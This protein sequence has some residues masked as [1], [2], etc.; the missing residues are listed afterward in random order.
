MNTKFFYQMLLRV[1]F[2]FFCPAHPTQC[3][4]R[5]NIPEGAAVVCPNHTTLNDPFMVCYAFGLRHQLQPM[6]KAELMRIP[7]IGKI[8]EFAGVI[9]VSRGQADMKAAK[10]ALK[11]LK[12]GNKLLI[13]PEGTRVAEGEEVEAKSGAAFFA[14]RTGAPMLPVYIPAK[15][16]WFRRTKVYVGEP[17]HPQIAG[18][19]ATSEELD[20]ATEE[21]MRRIHALE[22][23]AQ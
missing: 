10:S 14:S 4:G 1:I 20:A 16:L 5:E 22:E 17:F 23:Q 8:L 2:P 6:A 18:K 15:K 19:R 7:I 11:C 3:V 21:M 13:F 9:S 12:S